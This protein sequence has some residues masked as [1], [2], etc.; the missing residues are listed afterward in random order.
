MD[1]KNI[2]TVDFAPGG[3]AELYIIDQTRLPSELVMLSLYD[4]DEIYEAIKSLRVRGAPAI[5]VAAA[6]GIY[7]IAAHFE[8]SDI[9]EFKAQFAKKAAYLAQSRPTAVN[10]FWSLDR[11][12]AAVD[13]YGGFDVGE[14]TAILRSE[15]AAIRDEDIAMS[16]AIGV[17]GLA[18]F[19]D[20]D[21]VLTHCNAGELAAVKYGTAL[22]PLHV[23]K[24]RGYTFHVYADE[25]R[26]LLQGIRLTAFELH[27]DG[28]DVTVICDNMASQVMREGKISAVIVGSDR[29]A[30][31]G[32]V[33]NK[34]GTSGV[35]VLAKHY[36]IPFYVA[37]PS[38]TIDK[39]SLTGKDIPIEQRNPDEVTELHYIKRMAPVGVGVYNPA[40]DVTDS[41]LVTAIITEKGVFYPPYSFTE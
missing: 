33:C 39:K 3:A 41:S 6:I 28:I 16:Y 17:N 20:G 38:S 37:A 7:A 18:L 40:F 1:Y 35:A 15:A 34:I 24:E 2:T 25:T 29:I 27:A 26:P 19:N 32:D 31:N 10:L 11:M 9:G 13:V 8:T 21:G 23:G 5:G 14:L 22:A 12:T 4:A 36:G 30:A